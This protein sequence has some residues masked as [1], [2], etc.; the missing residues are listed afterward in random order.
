MRVEVIE[1][2]L[3]PEPEKAVCLAARN[4]Y[5]SGYIKDDSFEEVMK[6]VQGDTLEDKEYRLLVDTL[7]RKEHYGPFEHVQFAVA[8]KGISRVTMA[9]I[10]RHRHM[11]FDI[12]S[13]RYVDFEDA[14]IATPKSLTDSDHFSRETGVVD[15]NDEIRL[16][17]HHQYEEQCEEA[18]ELYKEMVDQGI[19]KEDARFI[20]PLGT[21]VNIVMSG[22][23]RTFMHV[24]NMRGKANAQ[25]EIRELTELVS[26]ELQEWAPRTYRYFDEEGPFR[27]GL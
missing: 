20:L 26:D 25:W 12:Q 27:L 9:Q 6:G 24:L 4:D 19:P 11:S 7:L 17:L 5:Y 16:N 10:T 15:L 2:A 18:V 21:R 8:L 23:L 22:N 3:S 13:M 14:D 1:E